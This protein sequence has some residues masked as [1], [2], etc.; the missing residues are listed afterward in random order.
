MSRIPRPERESTI[1]RVSLRVRRTMT[2]YIRPQM[3]AT[4]RSWWFLSAKSV[5]NAFIRPLPTH[6]TEHTGHFRGGA[7]AGALCV[8][9]QITLVPLAFLRA[10]TR[11]FVTEA[12]A[13]RQPGIELGA[14]KEYL[15]GTRVLR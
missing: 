1:A 14:R 15:P 13:E 11:L 10:G 3:G 4:D 2:L 12:L 7:H 9:A 5:G 6:L 8:V